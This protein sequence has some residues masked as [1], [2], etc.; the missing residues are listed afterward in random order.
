MKQPEELQILTVLRVNEG[1]GRKE[2][3]KQFGFP[4]F[5][6]IWNFH[7]ITKVGKDHSGHQVNPSSP[8]L[9]RIVKAGK[10]F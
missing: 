3:K 6:R 7:R 1:R 2:N 9:L 10:D 5:P 8:C 4:M